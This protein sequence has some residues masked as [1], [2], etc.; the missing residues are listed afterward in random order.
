MGQLKRCE[1]DTEI[2]AAA[3]DKKIRTLYCDEA[4]ELLA[5]PRGEE[6]TR[7]TAKVLG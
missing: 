4:H 5:H 7:A 2:A 3:V 1:K 6:I